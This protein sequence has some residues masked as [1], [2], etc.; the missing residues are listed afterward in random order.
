[1]KKKEL[2]AMK[3]LLATKAMLTVA[4]ENP[5]EKEERK[6][7]WGTYWVNVRCKY[8]RYLRA[9]VENKILK[10]AV[11]TQKDLEEG[12]NDP[13][14]EVYV[15][16]E[17][18]KWTTYERRTG[19]WREAKIDNLEYTGMGSLFQK[20]NWQQETER[21]KVNEYFKTG[22]NRDIFEA[23]LDFQAGIKKSQLINKHRSEIEQI[24]EVMREVPELPKNFENWIAKNCFK[25]LMFYEPENK[26]SHRWPKMYCTHCK[27]WM[28][29]PADYKNRPKHNEET[30]CPECK[31][32]VRY[33]SWNKQ[34][35][36][37]DDADVGILQ[38]LKDDSGWILRRFNCK[39]KR[40]REAGWEIYDLHTWENAR[41]RLDDYFAERE[42]FEY[43]EYKYNGVDRW[44]HECRRSNWKYYYG[45]GY[46]D[47]SLGSMIMYTPNLKRELRREKFH[48]MDLKA[49]MKIGGRK[50]VPP[51]TILRRLQRHPYMEY[52]QKSGLEK[53]M[54]EIIISENDETLCN[55]DAARI[56]EVLQLDKQ[57]FQRMKKMDGGCRTL[58]AL[59]YEQQTG[60]KV[61][62]ENIIFLENENANVKELIEITDRT[63]MNVERTVNYLKRQMD[64]TEESW[65][66]IVRY[67]KD[68]LNMA[69][70]FDMD[71]TDEIVCRQPKMME[72]HDKYVERKN[73]EESKKRDKEVDA[74]YTHIAE[75]AKKFEEHF[76]FETKEYQILVPQK[77]S[78][79]TREGRRQHH[80]VGVSDTYIRNMDEEK[81][82]IL[83][84]RRKKNLKAPYYTL[85]VTWDG[86]ISQFY[87]AYDRQPS[88]EKIWD[89]L[90]KFTASVKRRNKK[91]QA[92][93]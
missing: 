76:K 65:I 93:G 16:E 80:C 38:R 48:K 66:S 12:K 21:K 5:I 60:K 13:K 34:K 55:G 40:N 54:E 37:E 53:L 4:S 39:I 17:N 9:A 41:A 79:I 86:E 72:Y 64:M 27:K 15:D 83:F 19:K 11:F 44:C 45:Y 90:K 18:E 6:T 3:E 84:L 50:R 87:A 91:M 10:V 33:K 52:L 78:D 71:I 43:G 24:D 85:E 2:L 31:S 75:N 30:V 22:Q 92:A 35:Y 46:V 42:Y 49:V 56:H 81:G 82:F 61:S 51:A 63:K 14:Y 73:R 69:E 8:V 26:C 57:R 1:M 23:V 74:K 7:S 47:K 20:G 58:R 88:R 59:Q 68:Y 77:A 89:V 36:V 62:D 32:P 28:P 67:Y 70:L 25:E 29:T